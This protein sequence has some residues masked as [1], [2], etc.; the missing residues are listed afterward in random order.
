IMEILNDLE[1]SIELISNRTRFH[2]IQVPALFASRL[3]IMTFSFDGIRKATFEH[4]R[5]GANYRQTLDNIL[6]FRASF[7][8][9][10]PYFAVNSTT[11]R[12]NLAEAEETVRFW[13]AQGMNMV[14]FLFMVVRDLDPKLLGESLYP[15]RDRAFTVFD[16]I[17]RMV[18]TERLRL[19]VR[20]PWYW[21]SP[22]RHVFP[23]NFI[24]DAVV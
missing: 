8:G 5:R 22:L 1:A 10:P 2:R 20:C 15:I 11:M 18:I 13:N 16:D 9:K 17:A 24:K 14:R 7:P 4:I 3:K 19:A 21:R 23:R 6:K 12:C